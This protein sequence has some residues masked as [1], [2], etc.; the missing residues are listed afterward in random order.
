MKIMEVKVNDEGDFLIALIKSFL[1]TGLKERLSL[2]DW[3]LYTCRSFRY[4]V[5]LVK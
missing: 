3:V 5:T 2:K 4:L 1:E